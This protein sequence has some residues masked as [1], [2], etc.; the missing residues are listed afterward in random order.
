MIITTGFD[1]IPEIKER[2][3]RLAQHTGCVFVP[4]GR[5]SIPKMAERYADNDILVVLQEAVR[6]HSPDTPPM[7][8]HPSMGYVR[9]KRILAGQPDPLMEAA[10]MRPGDSVLDCTAGLG[11]DTLLFAVYGGADSRITALES[12]LPLF[13]L[14]SDGMKHYRTGREEVNAA[15]RRIDVLHCDHLAYLRAQPDNSVDIIYFDPMFRVPLTDSSAISPLRQHA[16]P[17][18]LAD[19][20]VAEA[21]RVARRTV[22]LKEKALSGEFA[23]LGFTE[24]LRG[25][26]KTSYGVIQV[27]N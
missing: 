16:N 6:L 20:S 25:S 8:F 4:R 12:S 3:Q 1:P 17:A 27:D 18:A 21:V 26:S 13:A 15:L 19:E 7:E 2:A 23:R 24:L 22:V 14:L 10:R 9:A 5:L 11:S